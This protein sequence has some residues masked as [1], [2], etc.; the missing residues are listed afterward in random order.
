M[1]RKNRSLP[2]LMEPP[3]HS[4]IKSCAARPTPRL[5]ELRADAIFSQARGVR[6]LGP[7][8]YT[9]TL[10]TPPATYFK[11]TPPCAPPP[12]ARSDRCTAA[13]TKSEGSVGLVLRRQ[14]NR[15]RGSENDEDLTR[16]NVG[17]TDSL[18]T[19]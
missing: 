12:F 17:S 13:A 15:R 14:V 18:S 10:G 2:L 6:L 11:S 3:H 16:L 8:A 7:S 19:Y 4:K 5:R 1:T 9:T